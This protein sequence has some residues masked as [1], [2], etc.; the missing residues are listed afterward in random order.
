M[1]INGQ[2]RYQSYVLYQKCFCVIFFREILDIKNGSPC[3][4]KWVHEKHLLMDQNQH[5]QNLL[6]NRKKDV[7]CLRLKIKFLFFILMRN[8]QVH[9]KYSVLARLDFLKSTIRIYPFIRQ[10]LPV[11]GWVAHHHWTSANQILH[12]I[13]AW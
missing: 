7:F 12:K 5:R 13:L 4:K 2:L 1:L 9:P 3:A 8:G 6:C 11:I 10:R